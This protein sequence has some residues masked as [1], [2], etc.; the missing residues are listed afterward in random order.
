[1]NEDQIGW[2]LFVGIIALGVGIV[3]PEYS[4]EVIYRGGERIVNREETL[5]M[6]L[7]VGGGLLTAVGAIWKYENDDGG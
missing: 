4:E 5:K 1:M 6:P 7:M 2:V 3:L